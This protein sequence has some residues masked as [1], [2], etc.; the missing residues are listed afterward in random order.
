MLARAERRASVFPVGTLVPLPALWRCNGAGI[1][2]PERS[3]KV[4]DCG[5]AADRIVRIV[6]RVVSTRRQCR[7]AQRIVTSYVLASE[8]QRNVLRAASSQPDYSR[9]LRYN[10]TEH[11][12]RLMCGT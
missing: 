7:D 8:Q 1:G 2:F 5:I 9:F 10:F 11:T 6:C 4:V 3:G 12:I